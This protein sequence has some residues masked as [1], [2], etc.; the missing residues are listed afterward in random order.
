MSEAGSMASSS[1]LESLAI[2]P[3]SIDDLERTLVELA[4]CWEPTE[5]DR[6]ARDNCIQALTTLLQGAFP[7]PSRIFP[8]AYG[9]FVV[10][11][12]HAIQPAVQ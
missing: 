6:Y 10:S 1:V 7:P 3:T 8:K 5:R 4:H 9:S 11:G 12:R 2:P